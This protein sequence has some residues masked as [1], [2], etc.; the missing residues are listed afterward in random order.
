MLLWIMALALSRSISTPIGFIL[1]IGGL[2]LI[3]L[4]TWLH[5]CIL[6]SQNKV[7]PLSAYFG[8]GIILVLFN[9]LLFLGGYLG[10]TVVFGFNLYFVPTESMM[11]TIM[12]GD[13][14]LVDTWIDTKDLVPG[15]IIVFEHPSITGMTLIK[16]LDAWA[17]KNNFRAKS[18]NPHNSLDS[19]ILGNIEKGSIK[20]KTTAVLRSFSIIPVTNPRTPP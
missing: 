5:G 18:D 20:A 12:P 15:D 2:L 13:I 11:P 16:R 19:R 8:K 7:K 3:H 1:F 9:S 14:V 10:K 17:D 4:S 6:I